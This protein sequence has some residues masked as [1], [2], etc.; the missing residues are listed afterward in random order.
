MSALARSGTTSTLGKLTAKVEV[1][2]SEDT[3]DELEQLARQCGMGIS[4]Y[5]RELL[6]IRAHG[7]ESVRSLYEKRL[8][9]V[10]GVSGKSQTPVKL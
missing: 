3:R 5:I 10:A 2:V 9:L 1:R 6:M 8:E 7:I 4:E